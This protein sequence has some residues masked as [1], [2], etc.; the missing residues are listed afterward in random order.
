M[1]P[2]P[3]ARLPAFSRE[4]LYEWTLRAAAGKLDKLDWVDL[5]ANPE[6]DPYQARRNPRGHTLFR[7]TRLGR[8]L[9]PAMLKAIAAAELQ[10]AATLLQGMSLAYALPEWLIQARALLWTELT[11]VPALLARMV[12]AYGISGEVHRGDDARLLRLRAR[13]PA[14]HR[15][16]GEV[17][18]ALALLRD[19]I[20]EAPEERLGALEHPRPRPGPLALPQLAPTLALTGPVRDAPSALVVVDEEDTEG[21]PTQWLEEPPIPAPVEEAEDTDPGLADEPADPGEAGPFFDLDR[22]E[23]PPARAAAPPAPAHALAGELLAC[24][25]LGWWE[26][27][28]PRGPAPT[29][30][31][32]ER[33]FLH[34]QPRDRPSYPLVRE[35]V[36]VGWTPGRPLSPLA[37]RLLPPWACYRVVAE[38][39][40]QS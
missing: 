20:R 3:P 15:R 18:E 6:A 9:P 12:E 5:N 7:Q 33:G 13:L 35:D 21:L 28:A 22:P 30:L 37:P 29:D 14:W 4:A 17:G 38:V 39:P 8:T 23:A 19:A 34:F 32:I 26:R 24:R 10:G 27:R 2:A 36:R 25:S 31:R 1:T 16:R 11:P 40:E